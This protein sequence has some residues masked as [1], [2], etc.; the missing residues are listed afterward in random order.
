VGEGFGPAVGTRFG[1]ASPPDG[2]CSAKERSFGVAPMVFRDEIRL[3]N[4]WT[5]RIPLALLLGTFLGTAAFAHDAHEHEASAATAHPMRGTLVP[6]KDA[7][8]DWLAKARVEYP[9][10]KCFVSD[11]QLDSDKGPI[12]YVYK[13]SGKPDRL[14]R[15]CCN[16]CVKDFKKDPDKYLGEIDRA[17]AAEASAKNSAPGA[18]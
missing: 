8:A 17:K 13:E 3:M 2:A 4:L 15:F 5:I 9:S 6:A 7:P 11:D 14:V 12:D 18:H 16:D 1:W 10:T